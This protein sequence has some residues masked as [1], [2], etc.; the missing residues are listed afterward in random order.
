MFFVNMVASIQD[1]KKEPMI[2]ICIVSQNQMRIE[3]EW[4]PRDTH[5]QADHLSADLGVFSGQTFASYWNGI[6]HHQKAEV[7]QEEKHKTAD[8]GRSVMPVTT[9]F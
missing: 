1:Y 6:A 9:F 3:P 4:I 8:V 2:Y 7:Q 5:Q